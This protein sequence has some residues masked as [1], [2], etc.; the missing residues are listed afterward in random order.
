ME[1]GAFACGEEVAVDWEEGVVGDGV[2]DP[3]A[4]ETRDV[5]REG[6]EVF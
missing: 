3:A 1:E 5:E 4:G 2:G 6:L